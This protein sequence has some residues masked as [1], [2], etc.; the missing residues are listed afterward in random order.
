[1]PKAKNIIDKQRRDELSRQ[2]MIVINKLY[3]LLVEKD[4]NIEQ[5]KIFLT[6]L[7][8]TTK[9]IF[10]KLQ[11]KMKVKDLGLIE[12]LADTKD[13]E[14]F[15]KALEILAEESIL[16]ACGMIDETNHAIDAFL[17][18]ENMKR[19]IKDLKTEFI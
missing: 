3:P 19:N 13:K 5:A 14:L 18:A 9:E 7:S 2:K 12:Q 17:T 15:Q 16:V 1:M 6:V 10:N 4:L 8:M 11:L